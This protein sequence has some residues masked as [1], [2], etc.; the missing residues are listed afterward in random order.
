MAFNCF[1]YCV[2]FFYRANEVQENIRVIDM[3]NSPCEYRKEYVP[4]LMLEVD[5]DFSHIIQIIC[6]IVCISVF[7]KFV[8]VN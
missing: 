5:D 8:R 3:K 2:F 6:I 1:I 7:I 4:I